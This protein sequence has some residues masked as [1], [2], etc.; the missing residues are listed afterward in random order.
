MQFTVKL[1][2]GFREKIQYDREECAKIGKFQKSRLQLNM[3]I[4]KSSVSPKLAISKRGSYE[5]D[6]DFE[7]THTLHYI[8]ALFR[9]KQAAFG[10]LFE[11][12]S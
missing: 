9:D 7:V 6:E 3:T 10:F 2:G 12:I 11:T 5:S 8:L 1:H 4:L